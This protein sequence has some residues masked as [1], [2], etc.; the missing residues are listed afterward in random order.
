M[1][2]T[3]ICGGSNDVQCTWR[4][5][6]KVKQYFRMMNICFHLN[7]TRLPSLLRSMYAA[8]RWTRFTWCHCHAIISV[9]YFFFSFFLHWIDHFYFLC[10]RRRRPRRSCYAPR[11]E[12][13]QNWHLQNFNDAS[14]FVCLLF[15]WTHFDSHSPKCFSFFVVVAIRNMRLNDWTSLESF[16]IIC[17]NARDTRNGSIKTSSNIH[18]FQIAN[19]KKKKKMKLLMKEKI[20]K[21]RVQ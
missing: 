20:K 21:K 14:S 10:R 11:N 8:M 18:I 19:R 3:P 6:V 12:Q 2:A 13:T 15:L 5:K 16:N 4:M 17:L 7:W 9:A 1:T